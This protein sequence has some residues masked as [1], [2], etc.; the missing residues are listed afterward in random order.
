MDDVNQ[1]LQDTVERAPLAYPRRAP[2]MPEAEDVKKWASLG[3]EPHMRDLSLRDM[4]VPAWLI[5]AAGLTPSQNDGNTTLGNFG[6]GA[7]SLVPGLAPGKEALDAYQRGDTP[8][9]I[10][11][12]LW[13]AAELAAPVALGRIVAR[14]P[15][16]NSRF[17]NG[18]GPING[19]PTEAGFAT[20]LAP[21]WSGAPAKFGI[22]PGE[23]V[24]DDALNGLP[25]RSPRFDSDGVPV[26]GDARFDYD[27]LPIQRS[28][29]RPPSPA[30]ARRVA[31]TVYGGPR[32]GSGSVGLSKNAY[33]N[34][35]GQFKYGI[36]RD[37]KLIGTASGNVNGERAFIGWIGDESMG[38]A[39]AHAGPN[40]I[41]VS[42]VKAL[43]E[44]IRQD[45]P[46]AKVFEGNRISGSRM[47]PAVR[48]DASDRQSVRIPAW[49]IGAGVGAG[50][51]GDE[52]QNQLMMDGAP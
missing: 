28:T 5:N 50:M 27:G 2:Y 45:Y 8:G 36:Y 14:T 31:Q 10:K 43:R 3:V 23:R 29:S 21:S 34:E 24:M 33:P 44:A 18:Y 13:A 35:S 30:E 16:G 51:L 40:S 42:G 22:R 47:G 7:L 38:Q 46:A 12:G 20:G 41:G 52:Q 1:L 26:R 32:D 37:G 11:N 39:A 17:G 25:S 6:R 4:T 49:M 15:P 9:T 19:D 48:A